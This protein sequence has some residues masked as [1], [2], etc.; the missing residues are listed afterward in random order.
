MSGGAT[1]VTSLQSFQGQSVLQML[2]TMQKHLEN[3]AFLEIMTQVRCCRT[4][5]LLVPKALQDQVAS[6]GIGMKLTQCCMFEI[7]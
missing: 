3:K 4:G 2:Y 7:V 5:V 1:A 6:Q